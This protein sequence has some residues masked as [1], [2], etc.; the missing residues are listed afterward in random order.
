[1][2]RDLSYTAVSALFAQ[3]TDEV[4]L[5]VVEITHDDLATPVRLVNDHA[6]EQ[7]E[8]DDN[9]EQRPRR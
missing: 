2:S 3:Q 8:R 7:Q 6:D 1:M 4:F 5:V 9:A